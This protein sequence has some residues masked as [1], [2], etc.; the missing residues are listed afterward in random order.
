MTD[1]IAGQVQ[2]SFQPPIAVVSHIKN[3]KLKGIAVAGEARL[4]AL[5][6][7]PTFT[8]AGMPGFDVKLWIGVLAPAGTPKA[9]VDK[10]SAELGRMLA[11]PDTRDRLVEQGMVPYI[12]TA[13]QFAALMKAETAKYGKVIKAANIKLNN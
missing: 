7:V 9:A 2:L 1:L 4:P 11:L 3:G 13:D 6:Q 5:P 12:S 10:L 8:Q